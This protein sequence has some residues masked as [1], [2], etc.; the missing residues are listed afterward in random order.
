MKVT[1]FY[2][3]TYWVWLRHLNCAL[4]NLGYSIGAIAIAIAANLYPSD[5]EQIYAGQFVWPFNASV[6]EFI[7]PVIT[8]I[9]IAIRSYQ[10]GKVKNA[11]IFLLIAVFICIILYE[12]TRTYQK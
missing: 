10:K 5:M 8:I 1:I 2:Y 4:T 6:S 9:V 12:S 11:M 7:I 3:V